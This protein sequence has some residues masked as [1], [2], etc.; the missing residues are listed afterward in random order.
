MTE[1]GDALPAPKEPHVDDEYLDTFSEPARPAEAADFDAGEDNVSLNLAAVDEN[2]YLADYLANMLVDS[3]YNSLDRETS[4]TG[5]IGIPNPWTQTDFLDEAIRLSGVDCRLPDDESLPQDMHLLRY[6][7]TP[8]TLE[9][10]YAN[11]EEELT[12]RASTE[13][14]G[15]ILSGDYNSYSHEWEETVGGVSVDCLGDGEHINV[16]VFKYGDTAYALTMA[17]GSEGVGLTADEL[18]DLVKA[19]LPASASDKYAEPADIYA[20]PIDIYA[21][22][23]PHE[24]LPEAGQPETESN[25]DIVVLFTGNV[26]CGIDEGFGYAGLK[27]LR[28]SLEAQG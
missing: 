27:A 24:I 5:S 19:M 4:T 15:Y 3:F 10:D 8:G 1:S 9:A 2:D 16:A 28:D 17:C 6:R 7:A 12:L 13:E 20:D 26:R 11:G 23:V 14:E 25:R 18:A 21:D 22:P